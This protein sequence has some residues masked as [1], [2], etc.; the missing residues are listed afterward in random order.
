MESSNGLMGLWVEINTDSISANYLSWSLDQSFN[1]SCAY[2]D[3]FLQ[4]SNDTVL[5]AFMS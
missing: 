3:G 1:Y 2:S 4:L 5:C